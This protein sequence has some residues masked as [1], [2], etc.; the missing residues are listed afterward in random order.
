[1]MKLEF[2]PLFFS[3]QNLPSFNQSLIDSIADLHLRNTVV[4]ILR[5]MKI[6][7]K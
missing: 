5:Q 7:S 1:M 4:L 6:V 3:A 2:S